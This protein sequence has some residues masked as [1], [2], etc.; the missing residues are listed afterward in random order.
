MSVCINDSD[1]LDV[2]AP[3]G[4]GSVR[5]RRRFLAVSIPLTGLVGGA[6]A[7]CGKKGDLEAP[8][9]APPAGADATEDRTE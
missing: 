1:S 5:T 3:E 8:L 7:A 4:A 9:P 2:E 6:L